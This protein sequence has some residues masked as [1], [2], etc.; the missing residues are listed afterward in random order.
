MAPEGV[1]RLVQGDGAGQES[2]RVQAL[3]TRAR[4]ARENGED[5]E[6]V[7]DDGDSH[8]GG[9]LWNGRNDYRAE[10]KK[11]GPEAPLRAARSL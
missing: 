2:V 10:E 3:R 8:G 7:G 1:A 6:H 4:P 11:G 5:G 9:D